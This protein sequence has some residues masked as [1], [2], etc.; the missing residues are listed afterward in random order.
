MAESKSPLLRDL[1]NFWDILIP[2]TA[3]KYQCCGFKESLNI[4]IASW[5]DGESGLQN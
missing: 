3:K 5:C 2:V 1:S 4:C